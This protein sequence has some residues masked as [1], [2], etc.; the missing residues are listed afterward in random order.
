MWDM[1]LAVTYDTVSGKVEFVPVC[2]ENSGIQLAKG[3]EKEEI[4][5]AFRRRS[6]TLANGDWKEGWHSFCEEV[7]ETY[8]GAI[9]NAC[10]QH[11]S[12]YDNGLFGHFL[13]CEAHTDVWRELFPS[14]NLSNEK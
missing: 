9:E 3:K 13:D 14:L 8:L 4:L 10:T 11:S 5:T 12:E 2:S 6:R 1:G 7:K